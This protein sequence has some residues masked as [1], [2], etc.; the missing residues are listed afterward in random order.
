VDA[1]A[2]HG[3]KAGSKH[4][5]LRKFFNEDTMNKVRLLHPVVLVE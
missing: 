2:A 3:K 4:L 5:W 1:H